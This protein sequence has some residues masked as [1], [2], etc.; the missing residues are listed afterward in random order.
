MRLYHQEPSLWGRDIGSLSSRHD[1]QLVNRT[2][3]AMKT[4]QTLFIGG[5]NMGRAILWGYKADGGDM[6]LVSIIDP[7][8]A[9]QDATALGIRTLYRTY[10]EIPDDLKFATVVLATKPQV[11]EDA[12]RPVA[13]VLSN[14]ALII[15]IMAGVTCAR[16]VQ[17]I[18][19]LVPVVR[20]M[21]NMAASVQKS[22]NVAFA[23]EVAS[24]EKFEALF[25]GSGPVSWVESEDHIHAT[26]AVSGSGPAYFFAFVEAMGKAGEQSGL[27]SQFAMDLAIDTLIG[28]AELLKQNRT[29]SKLRESV[30]SKSGTTAAALEQFAMHNNLDAIVMDAVM[31]AHN[32]SKEL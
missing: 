25:T 15:S 29:P 19:R 14:D 16:I 17:T 1:N 28:A 31:A 20:C 27:D 24:K 26:T 18:G 32:R 30:T 10:D 2:V 22:V 5:G 3:M 9:E 7:F 21:P 11:F 13:D 12:S 8:M 4:N 23:T 6:S